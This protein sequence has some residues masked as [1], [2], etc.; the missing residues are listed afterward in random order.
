MCRACRV[1]TTVTA[2]T[3]LDKTRTPLRRVACG[4][5]VR[6]EPKAR[7]KRPGPTTRSRIGELSNGMVLNFAEN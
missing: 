5:V 3:I 2:G 7:G 1:Q 6:H 4:D